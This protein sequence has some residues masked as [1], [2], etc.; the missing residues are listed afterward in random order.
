MWCQLWLLFSCL[1]AFS[2][3]HYISD[4]QTNEPAP[5][6]THKGYWLEYAGFP[7]GT[8]LKVRVMQGCPVLTTQEPLPLR[9][10]KRRLCSPA[11]GL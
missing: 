5:T 4:W 3:A 1:S 2:S 8:S 7:T 10:Q 11:E 6:I 9:R